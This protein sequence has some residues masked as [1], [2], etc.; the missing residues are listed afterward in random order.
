MHC[1]DVVRAEDWVVARRALLED[2]ARL[3]HQLYADPRDLPWVGGGQTIARRATNGMPLALFGA[4]EQAAEAW[5]TLFDNLEG[6]LRTL[7]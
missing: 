4:P 2:L 7:N 5:S 3:R 6:Y 1:Q